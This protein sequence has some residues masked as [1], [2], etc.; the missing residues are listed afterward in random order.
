MKTPYDVLLE[1]LWKREESSTTALDPRLAIP[2]IV[3]EED[4]DFY[5]VVTRVQ[6][7]VW[8]SD[9]TPAIK[10]YFHLQGGKTKGI[11]I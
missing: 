1:K 8:F 2:H 10:Q 11:F 6:K 3:L 9:E 7:G 4:N 5:I